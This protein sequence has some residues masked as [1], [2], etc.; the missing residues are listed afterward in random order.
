MHTVMTN[1]PIY[2]VG[3][4]ATTVMPTRLTVASEGEPAFS[5]IELRRTKGNM[6]RSCHSLVG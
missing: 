4:L 3:E 2:L 5:H 6:N 1:L